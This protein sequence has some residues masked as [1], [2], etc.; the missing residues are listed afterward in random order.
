MNSDA[1]LWIDTLKLQPHPEGGWFREFYRSAELISAK[2]LP[3]RFAGPRAYST[4]IYFLL[5][6][7]EHS[8]LHRIAADEGWHFLDGWPLTL[9][10]IDP[11]GHYST[12]TIGRN[13]IQGL[14]PCA[15]VPAGWL[16]GATVQTGWALVSCTVAPGF[17]FADFSLPNVT[18][19]LAVYPQHEEII[20][21][22]AHRP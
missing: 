19:L 11:H 20:R 16:F 22:L 9:H 10:Q 3:E 8:A 1:Q 2:A 7:G 14:L 21:R 12:Q 15:V 4:S 6:Q 18:E 5:T 13:P 17:D